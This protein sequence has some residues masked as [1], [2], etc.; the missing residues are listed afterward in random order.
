[1]VAAERVC[2]GAGAAH[3]ALNPELA[4]QLDGTAGLSRGRI[5]HLCPYIPQY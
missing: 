4:E 2:P 1:M 3:Y 5:Q